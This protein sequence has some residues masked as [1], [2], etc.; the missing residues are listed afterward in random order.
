[1]FY[2]TE[3]VGHVELGFIWNIFP[4]SDS[5]HYQFTY[6]VMINCTKIIKKTLL[7]FELLKNVTLNEKKKMALQHYVS[8]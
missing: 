6:I 2:A 5:G 1:M 7:L 4:N 8:A 3:V